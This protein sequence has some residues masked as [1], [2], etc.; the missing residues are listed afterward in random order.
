[1]YLTYLTAQASDGGVTYID[2]AYGRDDPNPKQVAS[3]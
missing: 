3:R 1:V 2:D